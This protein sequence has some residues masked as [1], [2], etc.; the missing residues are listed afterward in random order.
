MGGWKDAPVVGDAG[1]AWE[2]APVVE[3]P[4]IPVRDIP[5]AIGRAA[6]QSALPIAGQVIG[7]GLGLAPAVIARATA[8][9][10][11]FLA[12]SLCALRRTLLAFTTA[13]TALAL[14]VATIAAIAATIIAVTTTFTRFL[15]GRTRF[16]YRLRGRRRFGAEQADES[17]PQ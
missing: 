11:A 16:G 5:G 14:A 4:S 1:N 3:N 6:K 17:L 8:A 10:T 15:L 9:F 13:F 2:R 12:A 7:T